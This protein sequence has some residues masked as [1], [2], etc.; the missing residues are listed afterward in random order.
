M[1][2]FTYNYYGMELVNKLL[3]LIQFECLFDVIKSLI[4]FVHLVGF[5]YKLLLLV[6]YRLFNNFFNITK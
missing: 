1:H 4:E 3:K 2:T 6:K 5:E